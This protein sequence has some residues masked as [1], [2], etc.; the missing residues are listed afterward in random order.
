GEIYGTPLIGDA[1]DLVSG[2]WAEYDAAEVGVNSA[3]SNPARQQNLMRLF[4]GLT[5]VLYEEKYAAFV[6]RIVGFIF[7]RL[8]D[9][10]HLIYWGGQ[11]AFD[12]VGNRVVF[13]KDKG[14]V[15]ELK[16]NYPYYDLM[17][18]VDAGATK[19]FIEAFWNAHILKWA[20]LDFNRHGSYETSMG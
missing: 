8:T 6:K 3:L 15:H 17:W 19:R 18:S 13:A 16:F 5:N 2:Q 4:V 7:D 11:L 14:M 1:I 20:S 12:L 9:S 10:Q